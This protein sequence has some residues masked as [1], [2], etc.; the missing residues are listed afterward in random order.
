MLFLL[1]VPAV[2]ILLKDSLSLTVMLGGPQRLPFQL[3]AL[4]AKFVSVFYNFSSLC[5]VM[6]LA[7]HI[8]WCIVVKIIVAYLNEM[9]FLIF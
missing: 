2:S 1:S 8:I 5:F 7:V 4:S 3:K 9:R 6:Y